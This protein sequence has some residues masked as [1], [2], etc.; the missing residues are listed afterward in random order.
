[1]SFHVLY[2]PYG[3]MFFDANLYTQKVLHNEGHREFYVAWH[4]HSADT[5]EVRWVEYVACVGSS[6]R[7]LEGIPL[8]H[9]HIEE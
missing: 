2:V 9:G 4:N 8:E 6:C 1:M 5:S 7:I 3:F